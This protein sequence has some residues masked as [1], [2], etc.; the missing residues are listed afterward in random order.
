M[1]SGPQDSYVL[2]YDQ[3]TARYVAIGNAVSNHARVTSSSQ[4]GAKACNTAPQ[5]CPLVTQWSGQWK[6]IPSFS[7]EREAPMY[8]RDLRAWQTDLNSMVFDRSIECG[9]MWNPYDFM[10]GRQMFMQWSGANPTTTLSFGRDKYMRQV[11]SLETSK[12]VQPV[13]TPCA[14]WT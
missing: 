6:G 7:L 10:D 12:M 8:E 9:Q 1:S 5:L 11:H 3:G 14:K 2:D 4:L 13:D